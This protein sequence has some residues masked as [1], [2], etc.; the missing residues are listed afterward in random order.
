MSNSFKFPD[1]TLASE[2]NTRAATSTLVT[3]QSAHQSAQQ[4]PTIKKRCSEDFEAPIHWSACVGTSIHIPPEKCKPADVQQLCEQVC[5]II[6]GGR[7]LAVAF[8]DQVNKDEVALNAAKQKFTPLEA[9][10]YDDWENALDYCT[11]NFRANVSAAFI[12][13][14]KRKKFEDFAA[15]LSYLFDVEGITVEQAKAWAAGNPEHMPLCIAQVKVL[16]ATRNVSDGLDDMD[17]RHDMERTVL[18]RIRCFL[19]RQQEQWASQLSACIHETERFIEQRSA[20]LNN[21]VRG[22]HRPEPPELHHEQVLVTDIHETSLRQMAESTTS[23]HTGKGLCVLL[24][25]SEPEP[26]EEF[27]TLS[28]EGKRSRKRS[29][30]VDASQDKV[31]LQHDNTKQM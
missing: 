18:D 9:A 19:K 30:R 11:W 28:E 22:T 8:G 26:L 6:Q 17:H 25:E 15:A 1:G 24:G 27:S 21:N 29:R 5:T 16:K 10:M 20:Q 7:S 23:T 12:R 2:P 13:P 31:P 3:Q 14:R 4:S